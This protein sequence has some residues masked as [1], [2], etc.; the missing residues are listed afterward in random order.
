MSE[1]PPH[2]DPRIVDAVTAALAR[3]GARCPAVEVAVVLTDD[4]FQIARHPTDAQGAGR[5]ASMASALQALGEAIA[6]EL[7]LGEQRHVLIDAAEGGVLLRR[8]EGWPFAL[9]AVVAEGNLADAL[10]SIDDVLDELATTLAASGA[11]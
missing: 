9:V 4:G 7:A 10:E 2:R 6:R 3:L 5:L 8:V 11:E 1:P